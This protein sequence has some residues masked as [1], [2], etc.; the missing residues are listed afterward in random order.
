MCDSKNILFRPATQDDATFLALVVLEAV[1]IPVMERGEAPASHVVEI[2]S[3]TD[4]LYSWKNA[5]IAEADGERIAAVIAYCGEGYH[6]IKEFTFDLVRKSIEFNTEN[7]DEET[8]EGEYYLDSAAVLPK[9]R[10]KGVGRK[11]LLHAIDTAHRMNL[12][13]SL[14]C[15]PENTNALNLYVSMGFRTVSRI[16]V[17]GTTYLKMV[18]H[19]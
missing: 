1:E 18:L 2:C 3:R 5:I 17:F 6:E 13:P 14:I 12:I 8:A 11:L 15:D 16:F 4:T 9:W 19:K 10:G 7:W